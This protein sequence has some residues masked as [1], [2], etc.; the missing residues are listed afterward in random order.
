MLSMPAQT[1]ALKGKLFLLRLSTADNSAFMFWLHS[2]K[3]RASSILEARSERDFLCGRRGRAVLSGGRP[4]ASQPD[5]AS[6]WPRHPRP[7]GPGEAAGR[8]VAANQWS[9][10][11]GCWGVPVRGHQRPRI[12]RDQSVASCSRYGRKIP[13][14]SSA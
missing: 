1:F 10:A 9:S 6:S 12:Q 8:L 13:C 11:A 14:G 5:V 2:H 7:R 4:H 3:H